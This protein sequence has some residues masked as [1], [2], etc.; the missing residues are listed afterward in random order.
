[1]QYGLTWKE[2]G[3]I[4]RQN[5]VPLQY[6]LEQYLPPYHNCLARNLITGHWSLSLIQTTYLSYVGI[7][8]SLHSAWVKKSLYIIS[9]N[10][11][12]SNYAA[13]RKKRKEIRKEIL[14]CTLLMCLTIGKPPSM[15]N[16]YFMIQLF[17]DLTYFCHHTL[18]QC[19][20]NILIYS[21]RDI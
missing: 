9:K 17:W 21:P 12:L 18:I 11:L 4:L 7:P 14:D 20:P 2:N 15:I 16:E 6:N 5:N 1:M 8:I 13:F 3:H 19:E 10:D